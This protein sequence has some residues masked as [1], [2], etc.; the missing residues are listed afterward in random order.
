LAYQQSTFREIGR[1]V[2][3]LGQ[4]KLSITR[5]EKEIATLQADKDVFQSRDND[6]Q[7]EINTCAVGDYNVDVLHRTL[8]DFGTAFAALTPQEQSEALQCVLKRV[9]IHPGKLD[10]E[11]FAL[12]DFCPSSQKR[13]G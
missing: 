10:L 2:K 4:G 8:K 11:V 13:L 12:E 9:T 5:L 1:Y 7:R 3:A 6:L